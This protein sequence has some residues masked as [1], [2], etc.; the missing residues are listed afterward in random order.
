MTGRHAWEIVGES[1][2]GM[3]YCTTFGLS[4]SCGSMKKCREA[5]PRRISDTYPPKRL[6]GPRVTQASLDPGVNVF[7]H[8]ETGKEPSGTHP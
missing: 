4:N 6:T 3:A 8:W 1:G 2:I 5:K 7:D